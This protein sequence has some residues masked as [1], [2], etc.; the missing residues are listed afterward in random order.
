M[1][2]RESALHNGGWEIDQWWMSVRRAFT[3]TAAFPTLSSQDP[4]RVGC[5][6]RR[7]RRGAAASSSTRCWAQVSIRDN[8][9]FSSPP[10]GCLC[11]KLAPTSPPPKMLLVEI[12]THNHPSIKKQTFMRAAGVFLWLL[13]A[14]QAQLCISILSAF[15]GVMEAHCVEALFEWGMTV[16]HI[17]SNPRG[18]GLVYLAFAQRA[19]PKLKT[20][21]GLYSANMLRVMNNMLLKFPVR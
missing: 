16:M 10:S 1:L 18:K 15:D 12:F 7:A 13:A 4:S 2:M 8:S 20:S 11:K 3:S 21:N 5:S 17:Q 14:F 6:A 19:S 9:W